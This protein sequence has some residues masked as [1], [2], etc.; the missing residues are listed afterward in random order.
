MLERRRHCA[1]QRSGDLSWD[2]ERFHR[3]AFRG[4]SAELIEALR[5]S[6]K[7]TLGSMAEQLTAQGV[8]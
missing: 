7:P 6:N 1:R 3:V 5:Q 4:A 2:G 8:V